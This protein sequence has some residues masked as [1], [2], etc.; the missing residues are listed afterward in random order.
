[1]IS[2][3]AGWRSAAC[4]WVGLGMAACSSSGPPG[5]SAGELTPVTSADIHRLVRE[6]GAGAVL[7][8]CWATWCDPCR[9]EFPDLV[10]LSRRY[11]EKGLKT[12]FVSADSEEEMDAVRRFL[13]AQGVDFPTYLKAEKDQP[14]IDGLERR[15]TGAL[16]ATLLFDGKGRPRGFWE[17]P[18]AMEELEKNIV[19]LLGESATFQGG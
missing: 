18:V 8:N 3:L 14:F 12:L 17:G 2:T 15:W 10:R 19:E 5:K 4:L 6:A 13:K 11:R 1:M 7:V 16:P 9:E